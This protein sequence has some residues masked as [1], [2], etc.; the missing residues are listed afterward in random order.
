M[1]RAP[2]GDPWGPDLFS[3]RGHALVAAW[4]VAI[5][6]AL[7]L[8]MVWPANVPWVA[9]EPYLIRSAIEANE[10]GR[11]SV[12]GNLGS[13]GFR[14]GP[15]PLWV[16]QVFTVL[17][18]DPVRLVMMRVVLVSAI[19]MVSLV[20]LA[21]TLKLHRGYVIVILL[22]P[23]LWY[24]SR[25]L[26]DSTFAMPLCVLATAAYVHYLDRKRP[27][28]LLTALACLPALMMIHPMSI[29]FVAGM[30]LH[31][32]GFK[33]AALW[34]YRWR[35]V[36]LIIAATAV[37]WPYVSRTLLPALTIDT[38]AE[39][40]RSRLPGLVFPLLGARYLSGVGLNWFYAD[41]WQ[42]A[43]PPVRS[44]I[45]RV[46]VIM[47]A[48]AYALSWLGLAI[49][50]VRW[51]RLWRRREGA[52]V[53]DH[54]ALLAVMI[55]A[56][57]IPVNAW[58]ARYG[59]PQYYNATWIA[60][61]LLAW[62]AVNAIAAR[63]RILAH[64]LVGA[65]GLA[66]AAVIICLLLH[67]GATGGTRDVG[68][69]PTL[70]VQL[71]IARRRARYD[72]ASKLHTRIDFFIKSPRSLRLLD[73][74]TPRPA[75]LKPPTALLLRYTNDDPADAHLTIEP[76]RPQDQSAYWLH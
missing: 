45:Y 27:A 11:I 1:T 20:W 8:R 41:A 16:Y 63:S 35:I 56:A 66:L 21:R 29:A 69:G 67:I 33:R 43:M 28:A 17:T 14:Y 31:S 74:L 30:S 23:Y 52:N 64:G 36:T 2:R 48:V 54:A 42:A 10:Q 49:T 73:E 60:A 70:A 75:T 18:R 37:C 68:H 4:G 5:L 13:K 65:H 59:L 47:S 12:M 40:D 26:W 7:A 39:P 62:M 19:T 44:A 9:D 71:D 32:L 53:R 22:G 6:A 15:L 24:Y 58:P 25:L 38:G 3:V 51:R 46:A 55:I 50:L 61:A 76:A 72:P 34:R 57:Q